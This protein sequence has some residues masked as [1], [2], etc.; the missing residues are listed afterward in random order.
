M[1]HVAPDVDA[2]V[3]AGDTA[4]GT[5]KAF[6]L[7]RAAF[8]RPVPLI[9]VLGNREFHGSPLGR[10]RSKARALAPEYGIVL[11]DETIAHVAGIRFVDTTLWS[12][13][14]LDGIADQPD[15]MFAA[16]SG[17]EDHARISLLGDPWLRFSPYD[18]LA[19]NHAAR[20]FLRTELT[21]RYDGTTVV[22]THHAPSRRSL[23]PRPANR[24]LDG[25]FASNL[26]EMVESSGAA[27]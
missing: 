24:M 9:V 14:A 26:D 11:L 21:R 5:G 19:P 13:Y 6:A 27:L 8:P 3:V 4:A 12:E 20:R 1:P 25:C 22:V 18:A 2:V 10:E 7:L 15:A 23:G 16:A 17:M